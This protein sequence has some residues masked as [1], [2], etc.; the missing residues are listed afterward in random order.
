MK[1]SMKLWMFAALLIGC[2]TL[3]GCKS[4]TA[5]DQPETTVTE[6]VKDVTLYDAIDQYLT[7]EIGRQYSLGEVSI[8][9]ATIVAINDDNTDDILVWGDYWIFNYNLKGDT[10]KT[11]SGGSHPGLMH[12]RTTED[13]YEVFNFDAV[14]DGAGSTE[15]AKQIFGDHYDSFQAI[16]SDDEKREND[17]ASITA[18]YVKEHK[19]KATM[20]QDYGWP[21][22]KLPS[23]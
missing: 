11:V 16:N 1:K 8:P 23:L 4:K 17:R 3:I 18:I 22:V 5:E 12:V 10:L 13:G 21:A 6:S 2:A 7:D 19:I 15:S 14:T 20:Y 9:C